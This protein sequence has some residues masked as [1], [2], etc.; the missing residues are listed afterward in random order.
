MANRVAPGS[1]GFVAAIVAAQVLT[2]IGAFTLPALLPGYIE[3]WALSKTE[4]GWLVGIFFAAYVPAVPVLLA[5]TDRLPARRVYLVG[6]GLTALSHLGFATA[7][8]RLLVRPAD[9]GAGR[10]S[11]G[12]A[13]TC[14][15]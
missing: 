12:P 11:A 8:R 2:Q 1:R 10:R 5:L 14:P 13:P 15:A 9:A 3:R 6:T 7:G 4:A